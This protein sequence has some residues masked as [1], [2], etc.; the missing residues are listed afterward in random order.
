MRERAKRGAIEKEKE[1]HQREKKLGRRQ[2]RKIFLVNSMASV[3]GY[4]KVSI[5]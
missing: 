3:M 1:K 2:E 5:D 4:N